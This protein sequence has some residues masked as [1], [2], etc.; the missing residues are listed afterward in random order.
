M[1]IKIAIVLVLLALV[2]SLVSGGVF[3]FK[4]KGST[5]RTVH[6]LGV[7]LCFAA[8][9]IILIVYGLYSGDLTSN[10]PWDKRVLAPSQNIDKNK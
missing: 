7:R 6:S 4:D 8:L 5:R 1:W 2:I 10:A 3:L 9:L